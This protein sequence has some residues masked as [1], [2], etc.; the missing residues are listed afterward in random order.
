[1]IDLLHVADMTVLVGEPIEIGTTAA[2]VR[3][4]IPILGGEVSGPK[5]KGRVLAAGAD[6]QLIRAD[7]VAELHARYVIETTEGSRIYVEN[8]GLRHG[9]PEAMERLR[10]G[11]PVDP[12]LI[13]FRT[14]AKFETGDEALSWLARHIFVCAG[15]RHPDRVR[16]SIYQVT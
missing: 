6:Y 12:A 13:Y 11:E 16:I 3:R 15:V 1:M 5:L 10:R 2:G 4:L 7:G 14:T 8:S 9:P